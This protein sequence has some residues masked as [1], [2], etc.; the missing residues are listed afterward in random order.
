MRTTLAVVFLVGAIAL[1]GGLS[2]CSSGS[3]TAASQSPG[4]KRAT[5]QE[6]A[7]ALVSRGARVA[8]VQIPVKVSDGITIKQRIEDLKALP[9]ADRTPSESSNLSMLQNLVDRKSL[10]DDGIIGYRQP[11]YNITLP[12]RLDDAKMR[13]QA[14]ADVI[15]LDSRYD[16]TRFDD[17]VVLCPKDDPIRTQRAT[18]VL[19]NVPALEAIDKF[20]EVL[21]PQGIN[22]LRTWGPMDPDG[23]MHAAPVTLNVTDA[24]LVELI[25]RFALAMGPRSCWTLITVEGRGRNL[26]LTQVSPPPPS[27]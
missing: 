22:I 27:Q 17:L 25:S 5:L 13:E 8:F 2:S 12:Q 18:L 10:P 14:V 6:I 23:P 4:F 9:E 3:K 26:V 1:T 19:K 20:M 7:S 16:L 21:K 11:T 15:A 24:P